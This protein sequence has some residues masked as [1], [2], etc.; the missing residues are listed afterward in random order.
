MMRGS[1]PAVAMLT[2]RARGVRPYFR[3]AASLAMISA[4]APSLTPEALPAVT[5]PGVR[6]GVLSLARPSSVVSGRGCSST[7]TTV[8]PLRPGMVTGT[9]SRAKNPASCAALAFCC[10]R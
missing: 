4:A 10:E 1:T 6:K 5:V 9:I 8:S 2:T 3:A 7:S